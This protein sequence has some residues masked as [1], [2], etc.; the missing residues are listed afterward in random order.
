MADVLVHQGD[1]C[2]LNC[3]DGEFG[4][5]MT[6]ETGDVYTGEYIVTPKAFTEQTLE[7]AH[8]VMSDNVTVLEI[9]YY[10]TS[11]LHGGKTVFIGGTNG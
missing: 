11:N 10:E 1:F 7:T 5:F 9:P 3:F 6:V 2:L 8:K 4:N